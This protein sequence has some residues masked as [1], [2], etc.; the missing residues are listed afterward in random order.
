MME[1]TGVTEK[2]MRQQEK[3]N[4]RKKKSI[5]SLKSG[6][7]KIPKANVE[8]DDSSRNGSFNGSVISDT[9]SYST[10]NHSWIGRFRMR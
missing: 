1:E 2:M 9:H 4:T 7:T 3:N 10:I 6:G 8:D 5:F